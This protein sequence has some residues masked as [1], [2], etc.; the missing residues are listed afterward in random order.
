[1][2]DPAQALR[3]IANHTPRPVT[4][5]VSIDD[6]L[7][8]VLAED[9]HARAPFPPFDNSAMDGFALISIDTRTA[10]PSG[11]VRLN[12]TGT[13]FAGDSRRHKL[14]AGEACGIMTGAALPAGADAVIPRELAVVEDDRLV[15]AKPVERSRHV[16]SKGEELARGDQVLSVGTLVHAGAVCA[17]ATAGRARV[18]VYRKPRVAVIA[19]GDETVEPGRPLAHGRIYDSNSHMITALLRGM[20]I[21]PVRVRCVGD[22]VGALTSAFAAALRV[23]DV[24]VIAGGVSVGDRDHVRDVLHSQGVR[25]VLWRVSQKPGKPLYFGAKGKRLVFG[26]PGN[27]ASVYTCFYIYVYETL[28]RLAGFRHPALAVETRALQTA[29]RRDPSRWRFLKA[30]AP[31]GEGTVTELPGQGSHMVSSLVQTNSLI[32]V[33]PGDGIIEKGTSVT[34]YRLP[35]E[36]VHGA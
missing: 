24:V 1:M 8:H 33:P 22:R 14:N 21:E 27:P 11:K 2:I 34:M 29:I 10:A 23:A 18:R 31:A 15:V 5:G 17:L 7:G 35:I 3:L 13:V 26:L 36:E 30:I 32:E 6:A 20:G 25:E 19:T 9:I 28:R 16:R 12:I 4:C